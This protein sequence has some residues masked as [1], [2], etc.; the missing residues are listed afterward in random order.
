MTYRR[1]RAR[2]K[3]AQ[4]GL[5]ASALDSS[6]S[7][8]SISDP[9]SSKT[10]PHEWFPFPPSGWEPLVVVLGNR[11]SSSENLIAAGFDVLLLQTQHWGNLPRRASLGCRLRASGLA[12][13]VTNTRAV[14]GALRACKR[15][16]FDP[17]EFEALGIAAQLDRA[18]PTSLLGWC[19]TKRLDPTWKLGL[20]DAV[21]KLPGARLSMLSIQV[22]FV[23]KRWGVELGSV[24]YDDEVPSV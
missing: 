15:P 8:G 20:A 11:E 1:T 16:V 7:G 6:L 19:V 3:P 17:L 21:G 4:T 22:G 12:F 2:S 9:P 5:I 23:L 10:T 18:S 14:Y 24:A 13:V